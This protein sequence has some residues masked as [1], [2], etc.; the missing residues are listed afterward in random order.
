M[1]VELNKIIM[2]IWSNVTA[3]HMASGEKIA[4]MKQYTQCVLGKKSRI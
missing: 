4:N 3:Y 2:Y 1:Y